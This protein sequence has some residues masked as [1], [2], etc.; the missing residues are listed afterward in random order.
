MNPSMK[1]ANSTSPAPVLEAHQLHKRYPKGKGWQEALKGISLKLFQGEI[2]TLLGPNGAGKTTLVKILAGLVEPDGGQI[3]LPQV[4]RRTWLGAVLEGN[5][6]LY[7]RLSI[8]ENLVYFGVLRGLSPKQARQRGLEFLEAVGLLDKANQI[9]GTLSRG[10]QQRAALVVALV[11][12]PPILFLDEPTLGVDLEAQEAISTWILQLKNDGK[13]ILLTT[14]QM[15]LA[16]ALA[17]RVAILLDG[18][19]ALEGKKQAVLQ[20]SPGD[21]YRLELQTPLEEG[22]P[23]L[24]KLWACGAEVEGAAVR[25]VGEEVLWEVLRILDPLPLERVERESLS[26]EGLFWRMLGER[27]RP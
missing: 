12:D 20:G 2:L 6:N 13:S 27:K 8:L 21:P 15:D 3:S 24:A 1:S 5:R 25:V 7:W 23:R 4:E 11:H 19:L 10:Q 17:D 16:E 14:H 9:V 22:D 26:L 18:V